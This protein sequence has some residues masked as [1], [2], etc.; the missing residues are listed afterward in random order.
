MNTS[1]GKYLR[2][3][4]KTK[5]SPLKVAAIVLSSL[6]A[7]LVLAAI[8]IGIFVWYSGSIRGKMFASRGNIS[9]MLPQAESAGEALPAPSG[10]A[11]T[12]PA[13]AA[14]WIDDNGDAYNYRSDV[15]A[16]LLMGIDY[17]SDSSR[18]YSNMLSNGGNADVMCLAILDV[19]TF[20]LS[21]LYIPR[22]TM[23]DVI[24]MDADGNYLDTITTNISTAHSYGDGKALSCRLTTDAVSRLLYGIPVNRYAALDYDA[25]YTLNDM[26]GGIT[27]TFDQDYPEISASFTSGKTATLNNHYLEKFITYRNID[28]LDGA[29]SRGQRSMVVLKALFN[30]CKDSI[31]A[32][33]TLAL[34]FL[35]RLSGQI[36]TDLDL[37]EITF[38]AQNIGKINFTSDTVVSLPGETVMGETYAEF[39]PDEAWLHDFVVDK[40]CIPAE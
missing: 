37:T 27:V 22:D 15:I 32:D 25:L 26:V 23:A 8:G 2:K 4:Q 5:S 18:W 11:Q 40:F 14:D 35:N 7:F 34:D 9:D 10:A 30:Q 24:V 21:I 36:S 6:A 19:N 29:Y 17:M 20:S 12:E 28:Q 16:I 33:P 38:L 39:Y 1:K 31:A 3:K 13:V